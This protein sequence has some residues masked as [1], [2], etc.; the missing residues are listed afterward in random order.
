MSIEKR[1]IEH[2]VMK[3]EHKSTDKYLNFTD[4]VYKE[5]TT[6][7]I[8]EQVG[9]ISG[10]YRRLKEAYLTDLENHSKLV[11]DYKKKLEILIRLEPAKGTD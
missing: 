3:A 6:F 1:D 7:E 2:A 8:E 9:I 4:A 10:L 5:L 11:S